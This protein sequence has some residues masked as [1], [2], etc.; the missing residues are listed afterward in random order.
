VTFPPGRARFSA[1][2]FATRS[3]Q[4]AQTIGMSGVA[5]LAAIAVGV[6]QVIHFE[7]HQFR[8]QFRKP[9]DLSFVRSELEANV[10]ALKIAKLAQ[11]LTKQVPEFVPT[12]SA[13]HQNANSSALPMLA[14][15]VTFPPGRLKL[16]TKPSFTG[17]PPP[18]SNTIGISE[19]AALAAW[20]G[21]RLPV[22]AIT[23]KPNKFSCQGCQPI[24]LAFRPA[25]F[26]PDVLTF[27]KAC[28]G[29]PV[30][31]C[32]HVGALATRPSQRVR[33][34]MLLAGLL[35]WA[36]AAAVVLPVLGVYWRWLSSSPWARASA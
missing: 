16:A 33:V 18:P 17:S 19:V 9:A 22:G 12:G 34:R 20:A 35:G 13:T 29:K 25:V 14:T 1:N 6:Y 27:D 4:S 32:I 5:C 24:V 28:L 7:P 2:P 21:I 15:P 11:V 3:P 30:A 36:I 31:E 8:G 23:S 10:L 26:D